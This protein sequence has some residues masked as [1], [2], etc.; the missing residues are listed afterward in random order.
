MCLW[1]HSQ[2]RSWL[3]G[4]KSHLIPVTKIHTTK[5]THTHRSA[6]CFRRECEQCVCVWLRECM[7][8]SVFVISHITQNII[9]VQN[10]SITVFQPVHL[11]PVL[12]T[13]RER[14]TERTCSTFDWLELKWK[15]SHPGRTLKHIQTPSDTGHS[16]Q[17]G[18]AHTHT[19]GLTNQDNAP[20]SRPSPRQNTTHRSSL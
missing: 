20:E 6:A 13:L 15:Y 17:W 1:V 14:E 9:Q 18:R 4:D 2:I 19:E 5:P 3:M 8:H 10:S 7:S 12:F 16:N 11:N